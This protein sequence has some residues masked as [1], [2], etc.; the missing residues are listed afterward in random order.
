MLFLFV[1]NSRHFFLIFL[2]IFLHEFAHV[3]T[4]S[5]FGCQTEQ[6]ILS[7]IGA[8]AKI[9]NFCKLSLLQKKIIILAGPVFNLILSL[10]FKFLFHA[11][12]L[13][14]INIF[15]C[16]FNLLP[17]YPLDGAKFFLI[18]LHEIFGI[19]GNK[20][21]IF[22]NSLMLIFLFILAL[23]QAIFYFPNLSLLFISC[24]LIFHARNLSAKLSFDYY[25]ELYNKNKF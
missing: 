1:S 7:G 19:S 22:F 24:F 5:I 16:V 14:L 23:L 11:R 2:F 8:C 21:F 13:A 25:C 18:L 6:I 20:F 9:N 3:I 15:I 10:V 17:I 12:Y 4:A